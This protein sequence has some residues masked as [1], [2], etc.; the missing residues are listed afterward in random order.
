MMA[1]DLAI[2]SFSEDPPWIV[3]P[4]AMP[5]RRGVDEL[6]D[7]V[8]GEIPDLL[9]HRRLPPVLRTAEVATRF[10]A[11]LGRWYLR[12]RRRGPEASR[13]GISHRLRIA[14]ARLGPTYI[15]LGQIIS[16]GEGL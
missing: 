12:E 15:K 9:G 5:W 8:R 14:F 4:D 11:V 3:D 6:R 10:G 13:R 2:G 7:Q 16:G 1:G